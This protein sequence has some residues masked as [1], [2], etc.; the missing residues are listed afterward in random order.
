[1]IT[2]LAVEQILD[3]LPPLV[4]AAEHLAHTDGLP[5]AKSPTDCA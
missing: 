3:Q 4:R 1:M 5:P 2:H